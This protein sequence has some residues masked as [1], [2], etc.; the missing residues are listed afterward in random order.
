[1]GYWS[2]LS[3]I[4][5]IAVFSR[6]AQV[7]LSCPVT[8]ASSER[9]FS[10]SKPYTRKNISLNRFSALALTLPLATLASTEVIRK[11][12]ASLGNKYEA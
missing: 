3:R 12:K 6:V 4:S 1:M 2:N 8:S 11:L 10:Y 7:V 9:Q 5:K